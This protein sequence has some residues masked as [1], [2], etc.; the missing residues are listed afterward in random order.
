MCG[1][2]INNE[3]IMRAMPAFVKIIWDNFEFNIFR[4]VVRL[5][6]ADYYVVQVLVLS[7]I[8]KVFLES[9]RGW[10]TLHPCCLKS[11]EIH[12]RGSA[13]LYSE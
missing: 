5:F 12:N 10:S 7:S 2:P 6:L 13:F 11:N 4:G 8:S 9:G 1:K 3:L